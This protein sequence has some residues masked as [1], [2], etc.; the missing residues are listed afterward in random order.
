MLN[1]PAPAASKLSAGKKNNPTP[2]TFTQVFADEL[3][4][5]EKSRKARGV[6]QAAST[7]GSLIGLAFSGGGIRSATFNLG[8]LQGLATKGLLS[9]FDYLSTVSGGGYIGSWL[10][11]ITQRVNPPEKF[12]PV[13]QALC[14][15]QYK[16]GEPAEYAPVHWL[17]NYADYLTPQMGLFS[18]D[19]GAMAGTWLRNVILNLI[20][21]VLFLLGVIL[22]PSVLVLFA[23]DILFQHSHCS[24]FAGAGLVFIATLCMAKSMMDFVPWEEHQRRN[25]ILRNRVP[26]SMALFFLAAVL[27]NIGMWMWEGIA[28]ETLRYW[29]PGAAAFYTVTWLLA[30]VIFGTQRTTPESSKPACEESDGRRS[31]G[32]VVSWPALIFSASGAGALGGYLLNRYS[33][34]VATVPKNDQNSW[35]TVILGTVAVM[36]LLQFIAVLQLGLLGRGCVDL[37]REWWA[38]AGGRLLVTIISWLGVFGIVIF[39]PLMVWLLLSKGPVGK[40]LNISAV[41]AWIA[42]MLAGIPASKSAKTGGE[43]IIPVNEK[44]DGKFKFADLLKSPRALDIIAKVAPYV[45]AVGLLVILSTAVHLLLGWSLSQNETLILWRLTKSSAANIGPVAVADL[46]WCILSAGTVHW[47]YILAIAAGLIGAAGI[48]SWRVDVNDFSMHHFYRNRLVRCYLGASNPDR[49]PQP[50]TG[51]DP[52]DDI[53]LGE[54]KDGYPGPYPILNAALNVTRGGELGFQER[55]AKSFVFTPLYCGYDLISKPGNPPTGSYLPT[56]LGRKDKLGSNQGISL[57]TAMAISGAAA[58]P[59]MGHYTSPATAFFMTLFDVRLGWWMGNPRRLKTWESPGPRLGLV[60]LLSELVAE[61]NEQSNYVYLSDGGHFENLAIYELVKRRCRLIMACDSG[62][63]GAYSCGDLMSVIE[64]CR[65]DFGVDIKISVSDIKPQSGQCVSVKNYTIGDIYYGPDPEDRGML[66][67]L[68]ASLPMDDV[69]APLA[70]RLA[71]GVRSYA[72]VHPDFPHQST[73][74]QWF[75]EV[76]FESYRA[77]GEYIATAAVPDIGAKIALALNGGVA[78]EAAATSAGT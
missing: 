73:A 39:G 67:Y 35:G 23:R 74:D 50:F 41:A 53:A 13:E 63:D 72:E 49:K 36:L 59:N 69:K 15:K 56:A 3:G 71:A 31:K 26:L 55:K 24:L 47:E 14:R 19:T 61:S 16:I 25:W 8:I 9:K 43:K 1:D 46:Y 76:Q 5:I 11:A 17:R 7:K 60:Y 78:P 33:W 75:N 12:T 32:A 64:K 6:T 2:V 20:V 57:G 28:S 40:G 45:F 66:I 65:T 62:A 4:Q 51:F 27:F 77:L 54:L 29:I 21:L 37:V 52:K 30:F 34:Y 10:A 38:R 58:S 44:A 70:A 22:L 18:A 48:L 42:S 68:K